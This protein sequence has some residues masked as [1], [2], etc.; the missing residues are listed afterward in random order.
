METEARGGLAGKESCRHV[1]TWLRR[2]PARQPAAAGKVAIQ[3]DVCV[4]GGGGGGER[5]RGRERVCVCVC[6]CVSE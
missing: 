5:E 3:P 4:C 1:L 2:Q 6:V